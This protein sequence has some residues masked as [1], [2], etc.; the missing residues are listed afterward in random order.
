MAVDHLLQNLPVDS[1]RAE[2]FLGDLPAGLQTIS[3]ELAGVDLLEFE[4]RDLLVPDAGND[5]VGE[6]DPAGLVHEARHV[7]KDEREHDER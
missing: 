3:L 2:Q 4:Q 1:E 5:V 6:S 7:Q